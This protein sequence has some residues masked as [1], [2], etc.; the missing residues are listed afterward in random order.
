MRYI[1]AMSKPLPPTSEGNREERELMNQLDARSRDVFRHVVENY[2]QTGEPLGS[3]NLSRVF[4]EGLSAATIRN[5]MG[6]LEHLGLIFA[7]H[8]SAGRLPTELG[9][10]FFVD[11]FMEIGDLTKEDRRSIDAQVRASGDGRSVDSILTEASQLLSGLTRSAGLVTSAK[12]D[13]RLKHIEFVRLE[14]TK[15]LVVIV[16]ENGQVENRIIDLPAGITAS[17]LIE[18]ANYINAKIAGLTLGEART[19]LERLHNE[20]RAELDSLVARMVDEGVAVWAGAQDRDPGRIIV[21]GHANLLNDLKAAEDLARVQQLFDDLE[22]KDSLIRLL[23]LAEE[24]E[25]VRIFIGAESRLFSQSGSSLV[26]APY[27]DDNQRVIGALGIIGPTRLNYA[28]IVPMI[29]YT[30]EVVGRM[31][32]G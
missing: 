12:Q 27:R 11:S 17:S 10:R 16:G 31:L 30:A 7:P 29:D 18:A 22:A 23:N 24:G 19:Q 3:R 26:V 6:D 15:A 5:V 2:L 14:P 28:R 1:F 21:S 25:G 32:R 13:L 8:T 20:T 9:L 4:S